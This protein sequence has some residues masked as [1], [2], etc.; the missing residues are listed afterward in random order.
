[1]RILALVAPQALQNLALVAA[2]ALCTL[3][4]VAYLALVVAQALCTWKLAPRATLP[5]QFPSGFHL[6]QQPLYLDRRPKICAE[7]SLK[8]KKIEKLSVSQ[9]VYCRRSLVPPFCYQTTPR[10]RHLLGFGT[11][12]KKYSDQ[13]HGFRQHHHL[14][15]SSPPTQHPTTPASFAIS[16]LT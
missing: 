5:Q 6:L 11:Q 8:W 12:S 4:L 15:S 9:T 2:Q 3:A 16:G 13:P 1:M 10:T 14:S 7:C